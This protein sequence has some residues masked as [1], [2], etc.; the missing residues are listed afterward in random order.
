MHICDDQKGNFYKS[1]RQ[2]KQNICNLQ[3]RMTQFSN[4]YQYQK[5]CKLLLQKI[6]K[7]DSMLFVWLYFGTKW[8]LVRW[9]KYVLEQSGYW[10]RFWWTETIAH[11]SVVNEI[12]TAVSWRQML[13]ESFSKPC[14]WILMPLDCPLFRITIYTTTKELCFLFF[15]SKISTKCPW[16]NIAIQLTPLVM[17]LYY[18]N[19][20]FML[21]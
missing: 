2:E 5:Y 17:F 6:G 14:G 9:G 21:F 20:D 16:I 15:M 7:V 12:E 1:Q 19:L 3:W 13:L 10:L 11:S 8:Q 4:D 18:Y